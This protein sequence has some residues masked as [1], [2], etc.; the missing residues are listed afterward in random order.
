M[1]T[2]SSAT[3]PSST[4]LM[5]T[6]VMGYAI[7]HEGRLCR[8]DKL[9]GHALAWEEAGRG[10]CPP[11]AKYRGSIHRGPR[12][13]LLARPRSRASLPRP[14]SCTDPTGQGFCPAVT[15]PTPSPPLALAGQRSKRRVRSWAYTRSVP[16][17]RREHA[18]APSVRG[19]SGPTPPCPNNAVSGRSTPPEVGQF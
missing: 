3:W 4:S 18:G 11:P 1:Q 19:G 6:L 5:F 14:A 12:D 13:W 17:V 16:N 7:A 2:R 10:A 15:D 8:P 9:R